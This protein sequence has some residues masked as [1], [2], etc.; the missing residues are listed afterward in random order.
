[1]SYLNDY[2]KVIPAVDALRIQE[3]IADNQE[4]LSIQN[5]N[6]KEYEAL[7]IGRAS[8]RERV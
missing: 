5:I 3:N 4:V 8:C 1:M 7:Q 2:L 6:E